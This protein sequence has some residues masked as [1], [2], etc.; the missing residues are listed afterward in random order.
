MNKQYGKKM[1]VRGQCL[2]I[3]KAGFSH[4]FGLR[5]GGFFTPG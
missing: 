4:F 1:A 3:S 5:R 2:N